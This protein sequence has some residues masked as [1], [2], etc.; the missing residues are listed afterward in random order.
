MFHWGTRL[1]DILLKGNPDFGIVPES[2]RTHFDHLC[3]ETADLSVV[4]KAMNDPHLYLDMDPI[5]GAVEGIEAMA[6]AGLNVFLCTTP[7]WSNPGCVPG[8]LASIEKHLGAAWLNRTIM[9]HD[10]TMVRGDLLIDDKPEIFGAAVPVWQ[11]A[12]FSQPYNRYVQ[13][14]LRME[15]WSDL[16]QVLGALTTTRAAA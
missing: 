3:D 8:K 9:T 11:Q 10:K 2:E 1:N 13:A 6:A 16:D 14:P 7:T 4:L 12:M 15:S 5:P